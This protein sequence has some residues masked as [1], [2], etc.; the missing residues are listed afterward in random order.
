MAYLV[1]HTSYASL[2]KDISSL[3]KA[4]NSGAISEKELREYVLSWSRN[5][6][7]LLFDAGDPNVLSPSLLRHI[8][9]KRGL[10]VLAALRDARSSS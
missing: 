1:Y 10:L 3:A 4:Y 8:G 9:K 2:A 6:P 7:N 5:C